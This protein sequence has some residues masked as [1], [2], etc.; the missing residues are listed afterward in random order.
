MYHVVLFL[1]HVSFSDAFLACLHLCGE[2]IALLLYFTCE[3]LH[4]Y[5]DAKVVHIAHMDKFNKELSLFLEEL[6]VLIMLLGQS[7]AMVDLI[8]NGSNNDLNNNN[9]INSSNNNDFSLD[10]VSYNYGLNHKY[11]D[12]KPKTSPSVVTTVSFFRGT[13]SVA[14][15]IPQP[16]ALEQY[17][18]HYTH[19]IHQ[20]L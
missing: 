8:N 20:Q 15:M 18:Q 14:G 11:S 7:M 13:G 17:Y 5:Q 3:Y 19:Y 9:R 10:G 4:Y 12:N 2:Y 1:V 6:E 16:I